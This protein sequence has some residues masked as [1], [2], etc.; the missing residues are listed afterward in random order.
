MNYFAYHFKVEPLDPG[1]EIL[2]AVLAE[3]NFESFENTTEGFTAYITE[4]NNASLDLTDMHFEEL[5]FSF[6]KEKIEKKNWNEEWEKN[7]EP[8]EVGKKLRI[9][10]PFHS[11][12]PSFQQEIIIMPKMSFGTGHHQTTRLICSEMFEM[13]FVNKRVLD[14]GCGTGILAILASR[15][16]SNDITGIDIDEWSVENSKENCEVN[17]CPQ[18]RLFLGDVDLLEKEKEFDIILANINKNILSKQIPVYS[19][20]L[21]KN[22]RLLLSGFFKTDVDELKM[23][24]EASGFTFLRSTSDGEWAM[25]SLQK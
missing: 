20:K 18:I 10:A 21:K 11:A 24:A 5:D 14:M 1:A 16:G 6:R 13:D 19:E 3:K 2:M 4:E 15:L 12:D 8:V 7:F 23:K 22:G 9:R 25:I 17:A